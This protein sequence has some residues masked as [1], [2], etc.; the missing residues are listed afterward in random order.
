VPTDLGQSI[1]PFVEPLR[2]DRRRRAAFGLLVLTGV[3]ACLAVDASARER[4]FETL[5]DVL[6]R[7]DTDGPA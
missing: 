4:A 3:V 2:R 5:L 6:G 7:P 1:R